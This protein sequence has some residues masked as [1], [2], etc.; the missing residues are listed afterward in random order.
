MPNITGALDP[1]NRR[2]SYSR[3]GSAQMTKEGMLNA[4]QTEA[5]K[6]LKIQRGVLHK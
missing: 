4:L 2:I 6:L 3:R 5:K 1:R